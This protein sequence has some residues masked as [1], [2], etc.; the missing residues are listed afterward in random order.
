MALI[1]G[2]GIA[3]DNL[4][5]PSDAILFHA[6]PGGTGGTAI[7]ES[8]FGMHNRFGRLTMTW[9]PKAYEDAV[10][11][12]DFSF[13]SAGR[14]Y[15]YLQETPLFSFGEGLSFSDHTL[16]A[17]ALPMGEGCAMAYEVAVR[18]TAGEKTG[19]VVVL[20]F[21]EPESVT[22]LATG[23]PLPKRML[24]GA[25]RVAK[26]AEGGAKLVVTLDA[27]AAQLTDLDGSRA[28]RAGSYSVVFSSG[29]ASAEV[30][31]P[32]EIPAGCD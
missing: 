31:L 8:L 20:A 13:A 18:T 7:A 4:I 15:R 12:S 28:L 26:G 11:F 23:T 29:V 3:I 24:V 27:A 10:D 25:T 5:G 2:E 21:L 6:Y 32:L 22:G 16:T 19:D 30:S 17:T 9:G 14:S 1:S